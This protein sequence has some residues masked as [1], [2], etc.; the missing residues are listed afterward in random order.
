MTEQLSIN[1]ALDIIYVTGTVNGLEAEFALTG[2]GIWTATVPKAADGRYSVSITA[3]NA[4]GTPTTYE[5]VL[6]KLEAMLPLKTNWT[7]QDRYNF[8]ELDRVEA[9]TQYMAE[10]LG[11]VGYATSLEPVYAGRDMAGF[12]FADSISRVERNIAALQFIQLPQF[13]PAKE[14]AAGMPFDYRDAN[15]LERN[16]SIAHTWFERMTQSF[17][18]CGTFRC[19]EGGEIF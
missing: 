8:E 1:L 12:E 18:Y 4:L 6:H 7:A 17:R 13:L 11:A 16:I 5:A 14:W 19:S 2:A 3:Y 15:R 10:R 9:N